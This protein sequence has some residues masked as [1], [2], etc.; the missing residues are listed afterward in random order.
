M[1]IFVISDTHGRTDEIIEK[2]KEMEEPDLIIHLGDYVEDGI[3]IEEETY[4][5]TII[6]RGNGDYFHTEFNEDELITI[7]NK[8]IFISHG[9]NYNV[10]YGED[11]IIYKGMELGADLILFGH[12]HIPILFKEENILVMNPGSASFPRGFRC[13]KTFGIIEIN[14]E[15]SGKI[16]EIE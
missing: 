2:I 13:K 15:L 4:I 9:H 16:I 8:K 10:R 5:E 3:R 1:R 14:E 7:N 6:V 11:N 12:T